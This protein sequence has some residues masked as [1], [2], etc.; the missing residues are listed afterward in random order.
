ERGATATAAASIVVC[1]SRT[2]YK[3]TV[4][5][6]GDQRGN[7]RLN[8]IGGVRTSNAARID[9][10]AERAKD[11]EDFIV[12]PSGIDC[13][14]EDHVG[15][16]V[17]GVSG[18]IHEVVQA[19][20]VRRSVGE[21]IAG[22][23]DGGRAN[24][25]GGNGGEASSADGRL[26]CFDRETQSKLAAEI[27]HDAEAVLA[28]P[29][30]ANHVLRVNLHRQIFLAVLDTLLVCG[31]Y[32]SHLAASEAPAVVEGRLCVNLAL[33]KH[34]AVAL[35]VVRSDACSPEITLVVAGQL[36]W[37]NFAFCQQGEAALASC[38]I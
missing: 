12:A 7:R 21:G 16:F 26:G 24:R 20:A 32:G 2:H 17:D 35:A 36:G 3:G 27:F 37:T 30:E 8:C 22:G 14:L 19:A 34:V 11:T 9:T 13:R 1:P 28:S 18:R 6:A 23:R 33:A 5:R 25:G 15:R 10:I 31:G 29:G 4:H 38:E